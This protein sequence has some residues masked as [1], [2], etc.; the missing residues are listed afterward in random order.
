[1]SKAKY[2]EIAVSTA[3]RYGQF[4]ERL[5]LTN[6]SEA[7]VSFYFVGYSNFLPTASLAS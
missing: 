2:S 7:W 1:M 6:D 5:A 4:A 3:A